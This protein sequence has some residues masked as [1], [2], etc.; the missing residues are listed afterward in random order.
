MSNKTKG[1]YRKYEVTRV[2]GKSDTRDLNTRYPCQ[3]KILQKPDYFVLKLNS[4]NECDL[5]ALEAYA[6]CV[7]DEYPLLARDLY[8]RILHYK[9]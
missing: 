4:G 9:Q 7:E 8:K 6:N 5:K 3:P 2:D 1:L